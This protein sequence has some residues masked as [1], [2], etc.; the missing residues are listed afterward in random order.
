MSDGRLV[1]P[2]VAGTKWL[3]VADGN[4]ADDAALEVTRPTDSPPNNETIPI[5]TLCQVTQSFFSMR[6]PYT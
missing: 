2:D 4:A 3:L 5:R 1:P 6:E